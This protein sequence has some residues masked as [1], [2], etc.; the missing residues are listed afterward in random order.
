MGAML[1][2]RSATAS[3]ARRNADSEPQPQP[4]ILGLV[5][6][7][8]AP[9]LWGCPALTKRAAVRLL[10][11]LLSDL[12]LIA[13]SSAAQLDP[14]HEPDARFFERDRGSWMAWLRSARFTNAYCRRPSAPLRKVIANPLQRGARDARCSM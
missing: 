13:R 6:D 2:A 11:A 7:Q 5:P 1:F 4:V 10:L 14:V 12:R 8:P 9:G 3:T